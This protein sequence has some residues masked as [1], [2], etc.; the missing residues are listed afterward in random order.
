MQD[1]VTL[2]S[3]GQISIPVHIRELLGLSPRDR[4]VITTNPDNQ[5]ITLARQKTIE[6]SLAELD[7]LRL[8]TETP[9]SRAAY[10]KNRGKTVNQLRTEWS[11]SPEGQKYY[12]EK[13][14]NA[15]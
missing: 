3:Q 5:S 12:R 8:A 15:N 10:E 1:T 6:Q 11:S 13:Y 2:S 7:K 4:F 9:E 14:F